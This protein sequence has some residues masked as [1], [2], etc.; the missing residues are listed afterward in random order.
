MPLFSALFRESQGRFVRARRQGGRGL[1]RGVETQT[2]GTPCPSKRG[3]FDR[4]GDAGHHPPASFGSSSSRERL[5]PK[6]G[7][8]QVNAA[9]DETSKTGH[10]PNPP[11]S[12]IRRLCACG[13]GE[14]SPG[15]AVQ[16]QCIV[17]SRAGLCSL[18]S[19]CTV[20]PG[21][22]SDEMLQSWT[23]PG[24]RYRAIQRN[25]A[26]ARHRAERYRRTPL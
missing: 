13:I 3:C 8:S 12:V 14:G 20:P 15:S 17:Q 24:A 4:R 22:S 9:L 1:H 11:G 2:F 19:L 21:C 10:S 26:S 5:V 6:R 23:S 18:A 7:Q 25:T 16:P